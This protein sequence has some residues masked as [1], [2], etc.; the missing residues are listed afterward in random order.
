MKVLLINGSPNEKRCTYTAL[1]EV[2][3]AL[4][5]QGVE[6]EIAW[7]GRNP[8]RGCLGCGGCS[9]RGDNR[10]IFDD[11]VVNGL[12]EKA[13][14]ADGLVVGTPVFYAGANGALLAVLDRMFYAAS[15]ALRFKPAA[16][17]ASARRAGTTPAIDQVNKYFQICCMPVVTSTYWP[18][19]HGQSAEQVREDAEGMQIM[20]GLG[21]NMAWMLQATASVPAPEVERKIMTN[22]IR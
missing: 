21:T 12:I 10:C 5:A 16:A 6:T 13:V 8:V 3:G 17:M 9:K 14:T 7:I 22:F 4:E 1:S 11:D 15:K 2:A 20:R 18:M 19:V